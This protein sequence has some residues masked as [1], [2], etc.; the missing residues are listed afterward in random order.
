MQRVKEPYRRKGLRSLTEEN[1]CLLY[2][3]GRIALYGLIAAEFVKK[4]SAFYT[5]HLLQQSIY[6]LLYGIHLPPKVYIL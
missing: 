5:T 2:P 3:Y 6:N 1:F 4:L